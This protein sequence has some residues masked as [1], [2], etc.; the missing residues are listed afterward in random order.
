MPD[1]QLRYGE[2][3]GAIR[4]HQ[5]Q[6]SYG[7]VVALERDLPGRTGRCM[8][9]PIDLHRL[10]T[11]YITVRFNEQLRAVVPLALLLVVFQ[12]LA[13]RSTPVQAV[14][15]GLGVG[16][17][18]FG[19]MFFIEGV[20]RGLM[21]FAE[22]IGFLLPGRAPA[23]VIL[24][25]GLLLGAAT[26]LAEPAIGALQVAAGFIPADNA[27]LLKTLLDPHSNRLVMAMAAGGGLAVMLGLL[28]FIVD[29][30]LKT[31]ILLIVPPCLGFTAWLA[32]QPGIDRVLGLAWDCGAI[33]TGPVTVPL[34][35]SIGIGVAASAGRGDNPL[36]GFGIVTLASLLPI[37]A[38]MFVATQ[39]AP[40]AALP[41]SIP[42]LSNWYLRMPAAEAIAALR[43][44]VPL[45]LLLYLV[46]RLLLKYRMR[47]VNVFVYGVS[48]AVLGM[49]LFNLGLSA[50]LA[51]LGNEAGNNVPWA[52]APHHLTGEPPLYPRMLGIG[53]V[54]AFA[55][56]IGFGATVA[57]PALNA[58]GLTVENLT[59]SAIQKAMLIRV[60]AA[61]V[62]L[63]AM[64]GVAR[65]LFDLPLAGLLIGAY[66]IALVLT[67][68]SREEFVNLAWDS[69]AVTTGPVTVPLL[70]ALGIGLAEAVHVPEGFG[71]LA[72][73]SVGPILTVLS[74]G[75]WVDVRGRLT[76][77]KQ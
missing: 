69:A 59:D 3:L 41:A 32:G 36:A 7:D 16:A 15:I 64:F 67:V 21:P 44:I 34:V 1:R 20:K 45:V 29:W 51:E 73:C 75:L 48:L 37:V 33:T 26:T 38:V 55:F 12:A 24:A 2:Y 58:A 72:L 18:V 27:G 56:V 61:G 70:L 65:I 52:F 19:L 46:Q 8:L 25:F 4:R 39:V 77:R 23:P 74:L 31:L 11:P 47:H 68:L 60:V 42:Q 22:H 71:I 76:R 53:L 63:G 10:V 62:G 6:V 14:R 40:S 9:R 49:I 50:G 17:V 43:A 54:L 57:E 13:L 35:L 28:R 30:P 66:V 5:R